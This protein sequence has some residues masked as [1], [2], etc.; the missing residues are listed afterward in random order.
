MG[1]PRVPFETHMAHDSAAAP[2]RATLH[3]FPPQ[4][5]AIRRCYLDSAPLNSISPQRFGSA[6]MM[7]PVRSAHRFRRIFFANKKQDLEDYLLMASSNTIATIEPLQS[8]Y[9]NEFIS[10]T[11]SIRFWT[12]HH[13]K[14]SLGGVSVP[15]R[16]PRQTKSTST[17]SLASTPKMATVLA[18][19]F[20]RATTP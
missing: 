18:L 13:A 11:S 5:G 19:T 7:C 9:R 16:I 2:R 8:R 10:Y 12:N 14:V 4:Q 6:E 20:I 1:L 15:K 3:R 17:F